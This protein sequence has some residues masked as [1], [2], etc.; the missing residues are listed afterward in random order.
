MGATCSDECNWCHLYFPGEFC[1]FQVSLPRLGIN[2][3]Q[4]LGLWLSQKWCYF[5]ARDTSLIIQR[6]GIT[7]EFLKGPVLGVA[8]M[9]AM[10]RTWELG[11][12][13]RTLGGR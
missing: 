9:V 1:T 11:C 12:P 7:G 2:Q 6:L 4:Q 10:D 3:R 13:A 5:K 8:E